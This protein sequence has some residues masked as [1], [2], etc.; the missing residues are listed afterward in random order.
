MMYGTFVKDNFVRKTFQN[1]KDEYSTI[2]KEITSQHQRTHVHFR[3]ERGGGSKIVQP[4]H[5][6]TFLR[7]EP[8]PPVIIHI[9]DLRAKLFKIS[10]DR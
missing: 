6:C 7:V 10:D 2:K 5:P 1:S 3:R 4:I 9:E 8:F